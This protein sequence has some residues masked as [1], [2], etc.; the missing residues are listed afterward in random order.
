MGPTHSLTHSKF[1]RKSKKKHAYLYIYVPTPSVHVLHSTG[2]ACVDSVVFA[3]TGVRPKWQLCVWRTY[4]RIR[5]IHAIQHSLFLKDGRTIKSDVRCVCLPFALRL[6]RLLSSRNDSNVVSFFPFD[7]FFN[8]N[9]N[10]SLRL[11]PVVFT[12]TLE[13]YETHTKEATNAHRLC[14]L[15]CGASR[16][17][18]EWRVCFLFEGACDEAVALT[19][20]MD[21]GMHVDASPR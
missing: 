6:P 19:T 18:V 5:V 10:P 16:L 21:A 13:Q 8:C 2:M 11:L 17:R 9:V 15:E 7:S 14:L 3:L 4:M 12:C 1:R 20:L